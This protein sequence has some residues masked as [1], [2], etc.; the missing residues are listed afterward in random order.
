MPNYCQRDD[1][2]PKKECDMRYD[3]TTKAYVCRYWSK[4]LDGQCPW[5]TKAEN[6]DQALWEEMTKN[7]GWRKDRGA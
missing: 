6:G 3:E 5:K 1:G 2:W 7:D 4:G